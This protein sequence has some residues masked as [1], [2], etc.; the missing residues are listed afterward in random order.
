MKRQAGPGLAKLNTMP[1]HIVNT[2]EAKSRLSELIRLVEDGADVIIARNG[3][4]AAKLIPW[5]PERPQRVRGEW[6][7]QIRVHGD[8][9][10]SDPDV[11]ELFDASTESP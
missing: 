4:P 5:P 11:V 6:A 10:G 9:V 3:K 1:T 7:G 2:H 8:I